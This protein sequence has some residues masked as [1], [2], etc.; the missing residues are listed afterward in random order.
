MIRKIE[1]VILERPYEGL[2]YGAIGVGELSHW[3]TAAAIAN[4]IYNAIGVRVKKTPMTPEVIL[5]ALG[6]I[7][8][9]KW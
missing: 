5:E 9:E 8:I 2:P 3:G 4:A 1:F 6:K 7:K